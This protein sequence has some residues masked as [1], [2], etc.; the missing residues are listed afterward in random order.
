MS[1]KLYDYKPTT[2]QYYSQVVEGLRQTPK[3]L[4]N[5]LQFDEQGSALFDQ[6]CILPEYYLTR[7]EMTIM[8]D[9]VGEMVA[10]IGDNC[11]LVEYGSGSSVK[12]RLLL[13]NLPNLVSY[14]PIDISKEH[15]LNAA[16]QIA[17][18][19]PHIE[20]LPVCADYTQ[21]FDIPPSI[22]P[23]SRQVAYFPGTTIGNLH[24]PEAITFLKMVRQKC[25]PHGGLLLAVDLKKASQIIEQ[26]YND[27]QGIIADFNKNILN[28]INH[29]F[30]TDFRPEQ[31]DREAIY[32]ENLGRMEM[33][34]ISSQTQ[35]V[36]LDN[37]AFEF[38][39]GERIWMDYSYKYS[40]NEF[41]Q[42]A[43]RA[44]WKV[45]QVWTDDNR[46]LSVQY[47]TIAI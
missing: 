6:I 8:T 40:L 47:L 30:G 32:N 43:S 36:H 35:T 42:L 21:P 38:K 1:I 12:T 7:T 31:F 46:L 23:A 13:D 18:A 45:E 9:C 37:D 11:L 26:A 41:A 14:V 33:Y 28:S 20:V 5:F 29:T 15:L 34:L 17:E 4:P 19:Y 25:G 24:P 39:A 3:M 10:H 44:G 2:D 22:R 16:K 27:S